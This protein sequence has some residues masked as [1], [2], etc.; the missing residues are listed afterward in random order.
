MKRHILLVSLLL[1][2]TGLFAQK[3]ANYWYFG[4]HAG[5]NF[6]LGV[7]VP[8]TNGALSTGEG[9]SSI[10]NSSGNLQLYTDGRFVYTREHT[11]MPNGYGLLGHSSSTQSGIIVPK[12]LNSNQYYIFTVDAWDNNLLNGVCYTRVDMTLNNGLGDVVVSEKNVPLVPLTCEKVTAVGHGDG[13]SYWVITHKWGNDEFYAFKVTSSGV[14]TTPVISHAGSPVVGDLEASKGYLKVS[15][16]GTKIAMANNIAFN[17]GI[18]SFNN[19]TGEV[20]HIVTDNNYVNPGGWDP[21]GPYGVEF[22]ANSKVLYIGEWKGNRSI[23][24]Y[25]LSTSNPTTILNSRTVVGTVGQSQAPIGALQLGPDNRLYIA[26]QGADYLSRINQP[27]TLGT[28][29]GFM[30][31]AVNLGGRESRYGLPPFVQSFFYLTADFYW[32]VPLC[33][34]TPVQFYTSA[35]D[36]PDSVVWN[37]GDPASGE[38]NVSRELNPSHL[39]TP[40][41]N[42]LYAVTLIVYLYGQAKNVFHIIIVRQPPNVYIGSDTTVC[43][44]TPFT[45]DADTGFASY[46]WQNG[47]TSH[48]IQVDQTGWYWCEVTNQWGCPDID[49]MY[50]VFNY[51]PVAHAGPDKFIP[52]GAS[53]L[54]EGSVEGGSG[55]FNYHWEPQS[56]LVNPNVLQP[57]TVNLSSSVLFTL[58]VTD[59]VG[60]CISE[61]NVMVNITGGVLTCNPTADPDEICIGE[62]SQLYSLVSGGTGAFTYLWSSTPTGFYSD[63]PNPAVEPS[64]TTTYHLTVSDPYSTV[65]GS[66]SITVNPLPVPDAGPDQSAIYGTPATL[67][68]GASSGSGNYLYHWEPASLLLDPNVQQPTTVYLTE[69][70]LFYLFVT[71][72]ETGCA[73]DHSD[74]MV[75]NITGSALA[76]NP[77]VLPGVICAGQQAQLFALASGGTETYTYTWTAMPPGFTSGLQDPIVFPSVTTTYTVTVSDGYN[78]VTGSTTLQVNPGPT[79]HL[80]ADETVC[81][82]DT[83]ILDAGNPGSSYLWSNGSTEQVVKVGTTGIGFD[84][85]TYSVT[86]TTPQGCV[87]TDERTIIFDFAACSGIGESTD[88]TLRVYPNPGNGLVKVENSGVTGDYTI[89]VTDAYGIKVVDALPVHFDETNQTFVMD[90]SAEKPGLYLI[91]ITN[92]GREAI[93][94]KYLLTR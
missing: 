40:S 43:S 22:S 82:F 56:L 77:S 18:F 14:V 25:D 58:M 76:V 47:D 29:C 69:E 66:T 65:N 12:P 10:S 15:P 19:I 70:T 28:G 37:F 79:I 41:A 87:G 54:L 78:E 60:G 4:D 92:E 81:V 3:E 51:A 85:K 32:D 20:T 34:G 33:F 23:H 13:V 90:L 86:V 88:G 9:C 42:G 21:G 52:S 27:N 67:Y 16:D 36:N 64:V 8:L 63:L 68:G 91:R 50:L 62:Q 83:V 59:N 39:F 75:V 55:N 31:N 2:I 49:S 93:S 17:V 61:D 26:R 30:E 24:Q 84:I 74:A 89:S 45:L 71:D 57:T 35:S 53:T 72:A 11:Q 44:T 94:G 38:N 48:S 46:L 80:G 73:S 7:P 6:G 1:L 5:L